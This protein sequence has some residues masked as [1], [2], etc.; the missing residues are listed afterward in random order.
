MLTMHNRASC[1]LR[2]RSCEFQSLLDP[3]ADLCSGAAEF[4]NGAASATCDAAGHKSSSMLTQDSINE[5]IPVLLIVPP[6][7]NR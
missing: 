7:A 1:V 2:S 4:G 5:A 3:V 6:A